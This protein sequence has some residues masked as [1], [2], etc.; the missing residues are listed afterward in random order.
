MIA[1]PEDSPAGKAGLMPDDLI[2]S[3]EGKSVAGLSAPQLHALLSGEVGSTVR[4]TV[5]RQGVTRDIEVQR[6]PYRT[7]ARERTGP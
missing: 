6:A 5:M 1:I 4:L 3:I 2:L 7:R